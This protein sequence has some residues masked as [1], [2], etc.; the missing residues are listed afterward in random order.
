MR[1]FHLDFLGNLPAQSVD[2][3]LYT[4]VLSL[5]ISQSY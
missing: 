3:L 1:L 4:E 5:K 2:I